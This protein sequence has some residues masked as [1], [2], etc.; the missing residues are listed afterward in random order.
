M[1]SG[2][3]VDYWYIVQLAN[4]YADSKFRNIHQ[5][6]FE[7]ERCNYKEEISRLN[8]ALDAATKRENKKD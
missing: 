6:H 5:K 3:E 2:Q 1:Q 8:S 7:E 4:K